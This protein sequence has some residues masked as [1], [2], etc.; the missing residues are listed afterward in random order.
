MRTRPHARPFHLST[1]QCPRVNPYPQDLGR[2]N[3][4]SPNPTQSITINALS[5]CMRHEAEVFSRRWNAYLSGQIWGLSPHHAWVQ[6]GSSVRKPTKSG[7]NALSRHAVVCVRSRKS[8]TTRMIRR[9]RNGC[10]RSMSSVHI[11]QFSKA[12]TKRCGNSCCWIRGRWVRRAGGEGQYSQT[13]GLANG[14]TSRSRLAAAR[15]ARLMNVDA[16]LRAAIFLLCSRMRPPMD[17]SLA[18][19]QGGR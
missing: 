14:R 5:D 13:N 2:S 6:M 19:R 3:S 7:A 16:K 11:V 15:C 8:P 18:D 17:G 4:S 1:D 9:M 10:E 12:A